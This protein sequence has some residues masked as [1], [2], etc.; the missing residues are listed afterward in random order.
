MQNKFLR[1]SLLLSALAVITPR[2]A[3][4]C[5]NDDNDILYHC[6][7]G[8]RK[9]FEAGPVAQRSRYHVVTQYTPAVLTTTTT[10]SDGRVTKSHMNTQQKKEVLEEREPALTSTTIHRVVVSADGLLCGFLGWLNFSRYCKTNPCTNTNAPDDLI[11]QCDSCCI[12]AYGTHDCDNHQGKWQ[13]RHYV[14]ASHRQT[15]PVMER[16]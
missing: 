4:G 14:N 2:L 5:Y 15:P 8:V 16:S 6:V 13:S 11:D 9:T 12:S 1:T 7:C 10:W 3:S